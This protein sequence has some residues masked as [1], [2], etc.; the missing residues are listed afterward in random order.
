[1]YSKVIYI[2]IYFLYL[3]YTENILDLPFN[4]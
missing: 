3:H 4:I 1:M 2:R